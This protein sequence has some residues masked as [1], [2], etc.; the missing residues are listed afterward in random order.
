MT[1]RQIKTAALALMPPLRE[2]Y[3]IFDLPFEPEE[4]PNKRICLGPAEFKHLYWM[5]S[6]IEFLILGGKIEKAMRWVCFV[7]GVLWAIGKTSIEDLMGDL[8]ST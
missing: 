6:Q 1:P 4:Y 8:I 5:L 3:S 7:Q 2:A